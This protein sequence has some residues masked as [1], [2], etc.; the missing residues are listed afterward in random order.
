MNKWSPQGK[1]WTEMI[2][3]LSRS[4]LGLYFQN[5]V[6]L[7]MSLPFD[8]IFIKSETAK[9]IYGTQEKKISFQ[10]MYSVMHSAMPSLFIHRI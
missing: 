4:I 5:A 3:E 8:V 10:P 2:Q 9:M 6:S 1:L 7:A